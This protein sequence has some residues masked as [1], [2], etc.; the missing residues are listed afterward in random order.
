[1]TALNIIGQSNSSELAAPYR[2]DTGTFFYRLELLFSDVIQILDAL[3]TQSL[4]EQEVTE[5]LRGLLEE[6]YD[7]LEPW[8]RTSLTKRA[9][10]DFLGTS[11]ELAETVQ[12]QFISSIKKIRQFSYAIAEIGSLFLL[13]RK[14][15]LNSSISEYQ[16]PILSN[17]RH[18]TLADY[19]NLNEKVLLLE[20]VL[21]ISNPQ[22]I[23]PILVVDPSN[24]C[25]FRCSHCHQSAFQDFFHT[26]ISRSNVA[27]LAQAL[28]GA[29][30]AK[31]FGTGEATLAPDLPDLIQIAKLHGC[32]T[33]VQTNGSTLGS[34]AAELAE[35]NTLGIS[36][37]GAN[38]TTFELLR[39]GANF[40]DLLKKIA[41]FRKQYPEVLIYFAVTVSR[42]N[43]D[44]I[45]EIVALAADL[46]VSSV[47]LNKIVPYLERLKPLGLR[48]SDKSFLY[49]QLTQA[50]K[51]AYERGVSLVNCI[52]VDNEVEDG[53]PLDKTS[54]L[55]YLKQIPI[56]K[57]RKRSNVRKLLNDFRF[58]LD[59]ANLLP[60][61]LQTILDKRIIN[62]TKDASQAPLSY[63]QLLEREIQL[64]ELLKKKA[65]DQIT[66]PYC[67]SPW[68]KFFAEAHGGVR[69]CDLW[70]GPITSL[71]T[72][73]SFMETW[74]SKKLQKLRMAT[75]GE[76]EMPKQCKG[77]TFAEKHLYVDE[78][79]QILQYYGI[80]ESQIAAPIQFNSLSQI[81]TAHQPIVV[82]NITKQQTPPVEISAE[83]LQ[84]IQSIPNGGVYVE[85]GVPNIYNL[86]EL[87]SNLDTESRSP[88]QIVSLSEWRDDQASM[89]SEQLFTNF[90]K[91]LDESGLNG[92]VTPLHMS[93]EKGA[94][95]FSCNSIN[96]IV[97]D[98]DT[99]A[100]FKPSELMVWWPLLKKSGTLFLST[101]ENEVAIQKVA[102][103]LSAYYHDIKE[104]YCVP[105][106]IL[107]KIS[108]VSEY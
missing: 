29:K 77:C 71:N 18:Y 72:H 24:H 89:T 85:L 30:Q 34:M 14:K 4:Y 106:G 26:H 32:R 64:V 5:E 11:Q 8:A 35:A 96:T 92:R 101:R 98:I 38:K 63:D 86:L 6:L 49:S 83:S 105:Y 81:A 88:S 36:F 90:I 79:K 68:V 60:P 22:A 15:G 23:P 59:D 107:W 3:N 13:P 51:I 52:T 104:V 102:V 16:S 31:L 54:I 27:K 48:P 21:G 53:V 44:E 93:I 58:R 17:T 61:I 94:S 46:G 84:V 47:Y 57:N 50:E 42:A 100:E 66:I 91:T 76:Q 74:H 28:L 95:M 20:I 108:T 25:N 40:N 80:T 69:P 70:G 55:N 65:A 33:E 103:A 62:E 37:D 87:V 99:W 10:D 73:D 1:M 41:Q 2:Q 67:T 43:I 56:A 12:S 19:K 97:V 45:A 82:P 75:I 9:L 39:K 7:L 78:I